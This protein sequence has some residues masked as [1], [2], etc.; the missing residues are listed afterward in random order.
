MEAFSGDYCLLHAGKR[1]IDYVPEHELKNYRPQQK[2][3]KFINALSSITFVLPNFG[4]DKKQTNCNTTNGKK[5][6]TASIKQ[7]YNTTF[8]NNEADLKI[9]LLIL[10]NEYKSN[11]I[12]DNLIGPVFYS[13]TDCEDEMDPVTFDIFWK[14]IDGVKVDIY[15]NKYFL[16]SYYDST[17]LLRCL[18]VFTLFDMYT[19]NNFIHPTTMEPI[20]DEDIIRAKFLIKIYSIELNLFSTSINDDSLITQVQLKTTNLFASFNKY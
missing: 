14:I 3:A 7:N 15:K 2:T 8:E 6:N 19:S 4:A 12:L 16:F 5:E 10:T 1:Q 20:P 11:N 18:T 13:I 17:K 9:K